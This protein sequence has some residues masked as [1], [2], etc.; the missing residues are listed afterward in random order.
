MSDMLLSLGQPYLDDNINMLVNTSA[1]FAGRAVLLWGQESQFPSILNCWL[2]ERHG[3]KTPAQ[4]RQEQ[5]RL[6]PVPV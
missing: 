1:K 5:V 2:I 4:V 3:H 6:A